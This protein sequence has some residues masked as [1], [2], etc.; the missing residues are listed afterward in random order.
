MSTVSIVAV[1]GPDAGLTQSITASSVTM[2]PRV[3][4]S[5]TRTTSP[6]TMIFEQATNAGNVGSKLAG[7]WSG[8]PAA[9]RPLPEHPDSTAVATA[10]ATTSGRPDRVV[11]S[12]RRV[13]TPI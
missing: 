1:L 3:A 12:R 2:R 8:F 9:A 6:S 13:V 4:A 11:D 5:R 7:A 10:I